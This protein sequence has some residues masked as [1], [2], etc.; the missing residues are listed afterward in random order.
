MQTLHDSSLL[1]HLQGE[2]TSP[3]FVQEQ[4]RSTHLRL[5]MPGCSL[6]PSLLGEDRVPRAPSIC[7]GLPG[8]H[9]YTVVLQQH[10]ELGFSHFPLQATETSASEM[11]GFWRV[12]GKE[13][14]QARLTNQHHIFLG[15]CCLVGWLVFYLPENT[16]PVVG[17]A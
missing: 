11:A 9:C 6:Q 4:P 15:F 17:H 10:W 5:C 16:I 2:G 7:T 13:E 14:Y 1:D 12:N 3:P 8:G